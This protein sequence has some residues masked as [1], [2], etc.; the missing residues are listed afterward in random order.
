MSHSLVWFAVQGIDPEEF[1]ERADLLDTEEP[2]EFFDADIAGAVFP[3]GWFVVTSSD[4]SMM[5]IEN[6]KE[7]SEGG[8][9]LAVAVEEEA[10]TSLATEWANGKM[11]WSI[12]H[13]P[14]ES[15][16]DGEPELAVEG[17]L[18]ACFGEVKDEYADALDG[19]SPAELAFQIPIEVAHRLTGFHHEE[20]GFDE[21]A[22]VFTVLE[23]Q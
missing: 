9:L 16:G 15:A 13:E 5:D 20:L 11:L 18:P 19:E 1:L 14:H 8:R 23:Q 17:A 12:S 2:D 3:G 6:L 10:L 4:F 22:P 21:E 7:W